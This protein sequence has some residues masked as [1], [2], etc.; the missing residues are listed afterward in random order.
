M[1]L[2]SWLPSTPVPLEDRTVNRGMFVPLQRARLRMLQEADE[3]G[4]L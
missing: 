3:R 2:H 4:C 1:L